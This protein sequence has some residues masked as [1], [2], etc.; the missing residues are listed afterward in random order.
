MVNL[1]CGQG[2]GTGV[3]ADNYSVA[4]LPQ[5]PNREMDKEV[6]EGNQ[7]R[8]SPAKLSSPALARSQSYR[9]IIEEVEEMTFFNR[10]HPQ[11]IVTK[12]KN[13]ESPVKPKTR[14]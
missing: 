2:Y 10:Y 13:I 8:L 14:L 3:V 11:P 12:S 5:G 4:A 7:S 1:Q 6:T 9:N